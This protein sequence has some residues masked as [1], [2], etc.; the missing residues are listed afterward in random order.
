MT[1]RGSSAKRYAEALLELALEQGAVEDWKSDLA[2]LAV[3]FP[4]EI[5]S[6]LSAPTIAFSARRNALREATRSESPRVRA[7]LEHLLELGRLA[8]L[9]RIARAYDDLLDE[10]AGV[11]RATVTTA[12]ALDEDERRALARR[13]EGVTGLR[14]RTGFEVRPEILGG[15]IVRVGDHQVD[16]SLATRL[17][18]LRRQ[19]ATA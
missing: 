14:L 11:R 6:L 1:L 18:T 10:R 3:A 15:S 12:V 5:S 7:L 2:R 4:V 17:A 13:L 8:L 9:P 16:A 19:L